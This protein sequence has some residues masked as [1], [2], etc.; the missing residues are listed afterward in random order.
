MIFPIFF[1]KRRNIK[2]SELL[3]GK[4]SENPWR[5]KSVAKK[6]NGN[7]KKQS[8]EKSATQ[9][10]PPRPKTREE[11]RQAYLRQIEFFKSINQSGAYDGVLEFLREE[12]Q[13]LMKPPEG[14]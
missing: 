2:R 5:R 11:M 9:K 4:R 8:P 7:R 14:K 6:T 1:P 12:L 13:K 3:Q 10:D